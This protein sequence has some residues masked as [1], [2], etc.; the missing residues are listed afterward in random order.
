MRKQLVM[1]VAVAAF[2]ISSAYAQDT[3][4]LGKRWPNAPDQSRS[5]AFH[6]YRFDRDGIAYVQVNAQD[7]SPLLAFAAGNGVIL[8]LPIGI[9]DSVIVTDAA[10]AQ[11]SAG[12]VVY[13][14]GGV[15]VLNT[16][17]G[18]LVAPVSAAGCSDPVECTRPTVV[19]PASATP[20]SKISTMATC[21]DPVECTRINAN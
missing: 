14:D 5:A 9:P 15:Q 6:A 17:S 8:K 10:T 7:G 1:A 4:G 18:Y 16:A 13:V 12:T 2:G 20:E 21:S 11:A 19:A 3:G